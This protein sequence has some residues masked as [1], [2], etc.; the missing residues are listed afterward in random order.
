VVE[1]IED[2]IA[3]TEQNCFVAFEEFRDSV[4]KYRSSL[5][6]Q[7]IKSE[8]EKGSWTQTASNHPLLMESAIMPSDTL[9]IT[10]SAF[11][12]F[13]SSGLTEAVFAPVTL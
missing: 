4:W 13:L 7:C 8:F 11:L 2:L 3:S 6:G 12:R 9:V 5:L 1:L 10:P